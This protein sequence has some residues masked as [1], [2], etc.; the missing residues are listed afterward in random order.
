MFREMRMMPILK[1]YF[2][3]CIWYL[4]QFH[5]SWFYFFS[6]KFERVKSLENWFHFE[7]IWT[8]AKFKV[9]SIRFH[10]ICVYENDSRLSECYNM[11]YANLISQGFSCKIIFSKCQQIMLN[12][13]H[14]C[15]RIKWKKHDHSLRREYISPEMY[16]TWNVI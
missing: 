10:S 4:H 1:C 11:V 12:S 15:I 8:S 6:A 13:V 14:I 7:Y 3:V 9:Y 5:S 2:E 16:V